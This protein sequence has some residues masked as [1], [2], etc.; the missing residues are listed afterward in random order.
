MLPCPIAVGLASRHHRN[1]PDDDVSKVL[2]NGVEKS[3]HGSGRCPS[4]GRYFVGRIC[5]SSEK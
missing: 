2:T 3:G 1:F 5:H 4:G